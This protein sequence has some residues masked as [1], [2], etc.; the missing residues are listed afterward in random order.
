[1][2]KKIQVILTLLFTL[3]FTIIFTGNAFQ[4]APTQQPVNFKIIDDKFYL[5]DQVFRLKCIGLEPFMPGESPNIGSYPTKLDYSYAMA[6]I[7]EMNANAVYLITGDPANLQPAFF[8]EA[9]E[10]GLHIVLGLWFSGEADDYQGHQGDFQDPGFKN[11][12]KSLIRRLVDRYHKI[13]GTDYSSQILYITL[14]NEF[15]EWTINNTNSLHPDITSYSGKYVSIDGNP[16]ECFLAEMMDYIK[17]YEAN[18]YG[19][20]HY[21]TYHTWPV[22]SPQLMKNRF[23]DI[24]AYNLYS[25]WPDNVSRHPGGSATGTPY[26]G[27]LEEYASIYPKKPFIV[28]E[29]GISVAPDN[30]TAGTDLKGQAD[31]I[32]DR[33][34]DIITANRYIAGGSIHELFDQWWKDDGVEPAPKSMDHKEHDPTDREEWF[35]IIEVSGTVKASVF[36]ERPVFD[37]IREMFK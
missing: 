13:N 4:S 16:T 31:E 24:I 1:M 28:S 30:V 22:V 29:F 20:I 36:R 11:H 35:G 25:Y 7:K 15:S 34:R 21:I 3:L 19:R 37:K 6:K 8:R 17:I 27:A 12:V 10:K 32:A 26:Q 9:K 23:L 14:G 33:W 5:N 18:T 2:N